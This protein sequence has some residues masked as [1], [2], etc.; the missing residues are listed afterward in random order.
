V[1][2]RNAVPGPSSQYK[3]V[4][5]KRTFGG[6]ARAQDHLGIEE[7]SRMGLR[8]HELEAATPARRAR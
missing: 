7:A 4:Q 3:T 6:P 1:L 2:Q 5:G 8:R